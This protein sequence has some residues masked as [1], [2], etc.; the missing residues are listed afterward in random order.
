METRLT[1]RVVDAAKAPA[2]GQVFLRDDELRGFALR[3]TA[4]GAKSYIWEGRVRGRPRRITLGSYPTWPVMRARAEALKIRSA[5]ADGRD[6]I[7]EREAQHR[8]A[9][10][11]DLIEA[12]ME[13]HAKLHKRS[14]RDDEWAINHYLSGWKNRRL[15]DISVDDLARLHRLLGEKNGRYA[16]NRTVALVRAMFNLG[17]EWSLFVGPNPAE[18]VKMFREE[19]RE[20]FLSPDELR[21]VNNALLQEPSEYWRAYF[22]LS[23]M[24]GTR[25]DRLAVG[26]MG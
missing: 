25:Q 3:I 14:W 24:L 13:R 5:V 7:A 19:K 22:P 1:Q 8:E 15:S 2:A 26:A 4:N 20:R 12:Y 17:R 6:P 9:R 11:S 16:A 23:L 18:G 21:R 10:F